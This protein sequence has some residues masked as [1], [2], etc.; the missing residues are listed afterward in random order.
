[1]TLKEYYQKLDKADWFYMMSDNRTSFTKGQNELISLAEEGRKLGTGYWELYKQFNQ[2][3]KD[4]IN[5]KKSE[6]PEMK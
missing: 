2:W 3:T 6:K 1:L 5:G 4:Q